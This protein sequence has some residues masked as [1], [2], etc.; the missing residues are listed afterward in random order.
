M[1]RKFR[2]VPI[3][4]DFSPICRYFLGFRVGKYYVSMSRLSTPLPF[5]KYFSQNKQEQ[6]PSGDT[7]A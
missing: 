5:E 6:F 3:F 2:N 7:M 4:E 1:Y